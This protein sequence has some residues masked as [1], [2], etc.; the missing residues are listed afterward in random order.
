[1]AREGFF[2][3]R[4]R[5]VIQRTIVQEFSGSF[6][7]GA[8]WKRFKESACQRCWSNCC[9]MEEMVNGKWEPQGEAAHK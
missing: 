9:W 8:A 4:N 6:A 3:S 1:M 2:E 7:W 5:V